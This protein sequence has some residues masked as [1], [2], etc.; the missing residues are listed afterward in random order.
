MAQESHKSGVLLVN[1]GTPDR[2]DPAAVRRY[3]AEFLSDPRVVEIPRLLWLP[4]LYLL[5]LPLRSARVA[6]NYARIWTGRGSPLRFHTEDLAHGLATELRS[7]VVA[8]FRYGQPSLRDGLDRLLAAGCTDITVLPAYPQYSA[9]TTATVFDGLA[10]MLRQRRLVPNL[11]FIG[12]YHVHPGYIDALADSVKSF[13]N[14]QGRGEHLLLSFHGL[15]QRNVDLGDPYQQQ[16]QATAAALAGQ[17]GLAA[18]DWQL[19]FQSRFGK[20]QWLQPYT[21]GI[22]AQLGQQGIQQL[23]VLCPGFAADCLETLEEISIQG[24]EIFSAAG[25]GQLRYIPALNAQEQHI[26]ALARILRQRAHI[27]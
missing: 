12:D 3:L 21:D 1:L 16:C 25:G 2:P 24:Q 20:A 11:N 22:L 13:W 17:L 15:P 5:I 23:D 14:G 19:G 6:K 10:I 26:Q 8:A 27:D 18:T 7:P 4:L 9:T